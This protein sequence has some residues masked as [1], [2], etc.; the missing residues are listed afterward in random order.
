MRCCGGSLRQASAM[1]TALS[2]ESKRSIQ[3]ICRTAI[4]KAGCS[5]I[6]LPSAP[7]PREPPCRPNNGR[8]TIPCRE[9]RQ[10]QDG[11]YA[12]SKAGEE[13]QTPILGKDN[14]GLADRFL[15][16][17]EAADALCLNV[18]SAESGVP[19]HLRGKN[20]DSRSCRAQS[21]NCLDCRNPHSLS[22][23]SP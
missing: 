3:M 21:V 7:I 9:K 16:R 2:P 5:R 6:M 10:R 11:I 8:A 1:T 15:Q 23:P 20:D 17:Q 14:S 19:A 22:P 4:Q 13:A 18:Q 12:F